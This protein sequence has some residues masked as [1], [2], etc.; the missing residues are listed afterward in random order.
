[1]I[2]ACINEQDKNN[3]GLVDIQK[4]LYSIFGSPYHLL[5]IEFQLPVA[6]QHLYFF[7]RPFVRGKSLHCKVI[8][9][10]ILRIVDSELAM[11][12]FMVRYLIL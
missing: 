10:A 1:M 12:H 4:S 7:G 11:M 5:L 3:N 6:T 9:H 8:P 2:H